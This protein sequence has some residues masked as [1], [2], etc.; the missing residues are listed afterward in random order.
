M[1]TATLLSFVLL[2]AVQTPPANPACALL[3]SAEAASLVGDGGKFPGVTAAPG[4]ATCLVQT[5]IRCR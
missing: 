4:G 1:I 5:L 3:T 2:S